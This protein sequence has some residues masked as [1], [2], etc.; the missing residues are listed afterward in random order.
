MYSRYVL[1]KLSWHFTVAT[2]SKTWVTENIDSVV[3]QYI[4]KWLHVPISGTLSNVYLSQYKFGQNIY[5]PSLKF[6]QCQTV[7]RNALKSSPNESIKELWKSTNNNTNIQYEVYNSRK[8]VIKNFI[9]CM[10]IN[11]KIRSSVKD[12]FSLVFHSFPSTSPT[13]YGLP[14]NLNYRKTFTTLRYG[15]STILFQH[16]KTLINGEYRPVQNAHFVLTPKR[17]SMLSLDV[18]LTLIALLGGTIQ[19][20]IFS[21]RLYNLRAVLTCSLIY[22]VS[23]TPQ[24]LLV[25]PFVQVC[26]WHPQINHCFTLSSSLLAMSPIFIKTLYGRRTNIKN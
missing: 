11:S 25:T 20:L 22:L 26:Y 7:L 18:N 21:C 6:I 1:T 5:P 16:A 13:K 12:P 23:K 15:M 24:L 9:Q 19:F 8:E 10:K 17:Y 3:N 4:R 14:L 2:L